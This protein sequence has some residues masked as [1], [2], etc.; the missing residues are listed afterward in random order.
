MFVSSSELAWR[1][2]ARGRRVANRTRRRLAR[3]QVDIRALS[4]QEAWAFACRY[5]KPPAEPVLL[6][7]R[8]PPPPDAGWAH[9][10]PPGTRATLSSPFTYDEVQTI[11]DAATLTR[12]RIVVYEH[13][14]ARVRFVMM[15]HELE[16]VRQAHEAY[17]VY[18]GAEIV[19]ESVRRVGTFI[20]DGASSIYNAIPLEREANRASARLIARFEDVGDDV[21]FGEHGVLFREPPPEPRGSLG[22]RLLAFAAVHPHAF[23][24]EVASRPS[25]AITEVQTWLDVIGPRV[26]PRLR[27]DVELATLRDQIQAAIPSAAA[28][29]AARIPALAWSDLLGLHLRAEIRALRLIRAARSR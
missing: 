17:P 2:G 28:I 21:R 18:E 1:A 24:A 10:F 19:R 11:D 26:W 25:N 16:H 14:D 13:G 3:R 23:E 9:H 4:T 8:A 7:F 20:G 12:H 22:Q 6:A 15:R 27:E 5:A 29:A